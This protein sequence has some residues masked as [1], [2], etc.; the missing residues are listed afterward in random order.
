M[1]ITSESD[2]Y[3]ITDELVPDELQ[4]LFYNL[5]ISQRDIEHAEKSA[6]T[7]DT[8]LKARAVLTFWKKIN[9]RKATREVLFEAR[10]KLAGN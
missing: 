9:G 5:G 4:L 2:I 7:V 1:S 8:R 10:R 6:D 3:D